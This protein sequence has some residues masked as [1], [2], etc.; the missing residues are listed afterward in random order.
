MFEP[1]RLAQTDPD[2]MPQSYNLR[3]RNLGSAV[4][5]A[6]IQDY[7]SRDIEVHRSAVRF[8]YPETEQERRHFDW[9]VRMAD[10][11]NQA[12]FREALDKSRL[13]WDAQRRVM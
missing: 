4:L 8:L 6:A 2:R 7:R 13:K 12:W 11:L 9:A 1:L 5:I 10:D 3:V